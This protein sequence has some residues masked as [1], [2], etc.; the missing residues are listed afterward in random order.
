MEKT[1]N[2]WLIDYMAGRFICLGIEIDFQRM[3]IRC[4][5]DLG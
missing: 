5:A 4:F 3:L 2:H 1:C